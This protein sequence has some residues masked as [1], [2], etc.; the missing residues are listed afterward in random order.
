M[1]HAMVLLRHD[2][3]D[4]TSHIDWLIDRH[5]LG[6]NGQAPKR[7]ESEHSLLTLRC[8]RRPDDPCTP[9]GPA[10]LLGDHRRLYLRF[11]GTMGAAK[12]TVHRIAG[13]SARLTIAPDHFTIEGGFDTDAARPR[14]DYLWVCR[15]ADS[16]ILLHRTPTSRA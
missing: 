14:H 13:G 8:T 16:R 5:P 6:P 4:G 2:L 10:E 1:K 12:G 15:V 9:P 11:E 7:D 3:P